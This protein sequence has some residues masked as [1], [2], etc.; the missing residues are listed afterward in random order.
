LPSEAALHVTVPAE[1][2]ITLVANAE[3]IEKP[4]TIFQARRL[5]ASGE[6]YYE[7]EAKPED[8]S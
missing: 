5:P 8:E 4:L 3:E 7:E 6:A 1:A 2:A